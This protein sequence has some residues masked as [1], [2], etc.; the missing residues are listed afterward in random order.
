MTISL[1]QASVPTLIRG[2]TQLNV[3]LA[4]GAA[5]AEARKIE[6]RVLCDDRL[7]PD[8]LPL[9]RQIHIATDN[10][11][12]FPARMAGQQPP[13]YE[14]TETTFEELVARVN[15]TI[16]FLETFE[17]SDIDGREDKVV[18]FK[19][20]P[21]EVTFNGLDYLTKFLLPNFYFHLSMV[22]AILRHN[23]VE[24]GKRDYLGNH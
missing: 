20:G 12:G 2:L 11:K 4:K 3:I 13:R 10:A 19:L 8:M 16:A 24:L 23:G 15:K 18:S 14:D 7:F 17:A 6:S 22:Y 5:Y 9:A 1:Y 21:T